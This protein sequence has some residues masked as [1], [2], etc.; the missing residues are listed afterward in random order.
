MWEPNQK[1]AARFAIEDVSNTIPTTK[2]GEDD[3]V[4]SRFAARCRRHSIDELPQLYH[5]VR[6]EM[7]FVGPRP[8]TRAELDEHYGACTETV[9][10][11]RP[12]LTGLWQTMGRSRLTYAERKRLDLML[13]QSASPDLY[14][15]ILFSSVPKVL[16]GHDAH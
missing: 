1:W 5:I 11:L 13:A 15:R 10:S 3:R 4:S 14:F 8:I 7:S 9:L 12:G 2:N 6:G 16:W